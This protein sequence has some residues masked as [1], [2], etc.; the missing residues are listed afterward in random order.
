MAILVG[1]GERFELSVTI[2]ALDNN[3]V[4]QTRTKDFSFSDGVTTYV[5]A[6][7]ATGAFLALLD[8]INEADIV[9]Y[10]L[11]TVYDET[12]GDVTAVG[13]P[14]KEAILSLR[15]DGFANKK[16]PHT[17]YS[18]YDAMIS[19]NDVVL[20]PAVQDYLDVFATGGDFTVSDGENIPV[21]DALRVA[22]KRVRTIARKLT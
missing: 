22:S 19:G 7:A 6:L 20:T 3:G 2:G 9:S 16:V 21:T 10:A 14:F 4:L 5:D 1:A 11:R 15:I 18:P 8:A 17:I 12:S 13:N